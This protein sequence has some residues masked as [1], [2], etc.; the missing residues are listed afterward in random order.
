MRN[1]YLL[2]KPFNIIDK[3]VLFKK[4]LREEFKS[5]H[6][7]YYTYLYFYCLQ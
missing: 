7:T 2:V 6:L 3:I 5:T 4:P 1:A